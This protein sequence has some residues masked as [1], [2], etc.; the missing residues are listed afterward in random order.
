MEAIFGVIVGFIAVV[1]ILFI[2][3]PRMICTKVDKEGDGKPEYKINYKR[4]AI[5]VFVLA[6][7]SGGVILGLYFKNKKK[8]L[9]RTYL[10][11]K[12]YFPIINCINIVRLS[13]FFSRN[14]SGDFFYCPLFQRFDNTYV[15][16]Y[17]YFHWHVCFNWVF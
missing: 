16:L 11:T 17:F 13:L 6:L 14:N 15:S 8:K 10:K 4:A 2:V 12:N 1:I 7:L 9:R 3:R 5:A